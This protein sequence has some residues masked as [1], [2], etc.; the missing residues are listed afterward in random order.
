MAN[1]LSVRAILTAQTSAFDAGMKKAARSAN[2]FSQSAQGAFAKTEAAAFKLSAG[3]KRAFGAAGL[4]AGVAADVFG[5]DSQTGKFLGAAASVGGQAALGGSVAGPWG[6]A[7]FGGVEAL[8]QFK[9]ALDDA[10]KA[11]REAQKWAEQQ[12]QFGT[13]NIVQRGAASVAEARSFRE[14]LFPTLQTQAEREAAA[15]QE[16]VDRAKQ[17]RR[18]IDLGERGGFS[19]AQLE[20]LRA[21]RAQ[22][23]DERIAFDRA[24]LFR[25]SGAQT[26]TALFQSRGNFADA[27]TMFGRQGIGAATGLFQNLREGLFV[28]TMQQKMADTAAITA[29]VFQLQAQSGPMAPLLQKGTQQYLE[30]IHDQK[31]PMDE[32]VRI[33]KAELA[34]EERQAQEIAAEIAKQRVTVN[35]P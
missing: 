21:Q 7:L 2:E 29:R 18:Q 33:A 5:A 25:D 28:G 16:I 31:K 1:D 11:A 34:A 27:A 10:T 8:K 35:M 13:G 30:A 12:R 4:A 23:L 19:E 24:Q 32:L 17:L 26:L 20:Q 22:I 9:S 15:R 6:A 3:M 14:S